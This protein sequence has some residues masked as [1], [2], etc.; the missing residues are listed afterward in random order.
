MRRRAGLAGIFLILLGMSMAI[1]MMIEAIFPPGSGGYNISP[2]EP[3]A[4]NHRS[5]D[6]IEDA[7]F[8]DNL[9]W[10]RGGDAGSALDSTGQGDVEEAEAALELEEE[11]TNDGSSRDNTDRRPG[12]FAG[13][14]RSWDSLE[15]RR[16]AFSGGAFVFIS[17]HTRLQAS[18]ARL[19]FRD[20]NDRIYGEAWRI[21]GAHLLPKGWL[22]QE[23]LER[24]RYDGLH[25][26]WNGD[27][28]LSGGIGSRLGITLDVAHRDMW[29]RLV[30]VRDRLA[31]WQAGIGLFYQLLPR[32]WIDGFAT[33]AWLSDHNTRAGFGGE[34]GYT[35]SKKI[36]LTASAGIETT[37]YADERP[38]YWSP[39]Y[40]HLMFGRL[41]LTRNFERAPFEA[42]PGRPMTA[43]E[44]WGYLAEFTAGVNDEGRYEQSLRGG[45]KWRA[46]RNVSL[47]GELYHL[48]SN[49]RF[50]Q[51]YSE[52]RLDTSVEVRFG[53]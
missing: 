14:T 51:D 53:E 32:W 22:L 41:R 36:G 30:N 7:R 6:G 21:D 5:S 52:N 2:E 12:V 28:R 19:R 1:P 39:A 17:S 23:G 42:L 33:G 48:D 37:S 35:I 4:V 38:T 34:A 18:G 9:N 25:G 13:Y 8:R 40:Y 15:I 26:D 47:R 27:A 43:A 45:V 16:E 50:S 11:G 49:G 10:I 20:D 44:R 24:D 3:L 46:N 31:L 29:E